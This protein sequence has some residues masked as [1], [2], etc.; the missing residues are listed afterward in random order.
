M[1]LKIEYRKNKGGPQPRPRKK[2]NTVAE[3][4]STKKREALI[5]QMQGYGSSGKGSRADRG[6]AFMHDR[7]ARQAGTARKKK[8]LSANKIYGGS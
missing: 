1:G 7:W 3:K 8:Y 4:K 5:S 6:G 2:A